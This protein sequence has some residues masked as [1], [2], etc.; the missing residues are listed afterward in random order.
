M[1]MHTCTCACTCTLIPTTL[2]FT[3]LHLYM[4]VHVHVAVFVCLCLCLNTFTHVP[5]SSSL[6]LCF[7]F[8]VCL[9]LSLHPSLPSPPFLSSFRVGT[10]H[11][12]WLV[13]FPGAFLKESEKSVKYSQV[14]YV[15]YVHGAGIGSTLCAH[16]FFLFFPTCQGTIMV[17]LEP[18]KQILLIHNTYTLYFFEIQYLNVYFVLIL[19]FGKNSTWH[20]LVMM[21]PRNERNKFINYVGKIMRFWQLFSTGVAGH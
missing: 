11:V 19:Y 6:A 20:H 3:Y 5:F 8:P 7:L 13:V 4:Y 16:P 14:V 10:E 1:F 9:L 12:L 15:L 18:S 17:F 21:S 2:L